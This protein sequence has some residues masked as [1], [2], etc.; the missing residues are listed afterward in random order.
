[1]LTGTLSTMTREQAQTA[2]E[3]RGGKVTA[4]VTRKTTWLVVGVEPGSKLDKARGLGV[5][6]LDEPAFARLIMNELP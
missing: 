5:P 4:S 6:V 3:A 2:I 1:V